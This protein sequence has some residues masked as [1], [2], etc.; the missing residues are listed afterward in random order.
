MTDT[1]SKA[2]WA[3]L[4]L[5]A[6]RQYWTTWLGWKPQTSGDTPGKPKDFRSGLATSAADMTKLWIDTQ[7][8]CWQAWTT[9]AQ[10]QPPTTPE[11]TPDQ[12][13]AWARQWL[14]FNQSYWRT[15][16]ELWRKLAS[17][18]SS[19]QL[20]D[21][22]Q[23]GFQR[24]REAKTP[25]DGLATFW[26][27]PLDNWRRVCSAVSMWPGDMEQAVRGSGSP[28]GPETV[29]STMVGALSMPTLGY[30]REWQEEWQRWGLL[31]LEYGQTLQAYLAV[32]LKV[33]LRS[34]ELFSEALAHPPGKEPLDSLRAYYNLWID[35]AETAYGE[36]S[37]SP[38]FTRAQAALTN[39]LF[40]MK[41]QEQKMVEEFLSALNMPTR[42]ELDTSHQRVHQLQRRLWQV[43]QSLEESNDL[44]EELAEL[45][46][47]VE[48]LRATPEPP[49]PRKGGAKATP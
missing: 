32:L 12:W 27:M 7:R 18:A 20:W 38:E 37:I 26:G 21:S 14:A 5:D 15:Q 3:D 49:A 44:R 8:A 11:A 16:E 48:A 22:Y 46:R 19:E 13:Q 36:I 33:N 4:W 23:Q 31:W 39:A 28:Y 35:C 45:R 17:G 25:W 42:G 43:E 24:L 40:A 34:G 1:L 2:S 47:E 6:Q 41:H 9:A 10:G 30:T 29:H